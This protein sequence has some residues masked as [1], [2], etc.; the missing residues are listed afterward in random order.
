[1]SP[2]ETK[3]VAQ[4]VDQENAAFDLGRTARTVD[5][6]FNARHE[7]ERTVPSEEILGNSPPS[8]QDFSSGGHTST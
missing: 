3:T 5:F 1:V 7:D 8:A 2:G 4:E 6:D